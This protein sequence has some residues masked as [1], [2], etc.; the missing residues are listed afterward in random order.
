MTIRPR[1]SA[2]YM[3]GSNARAMEKAR[4]L[5]ADCIILDLED[6]V[7]PDQ[8]AQAR[9]AVVDTLRQGKFGAR[10]VA[11]RINSLESPWGRDDLAALAPLGADALLLP[12]VSHP[13]EIMRA[14]KEARD[15]G[16]RDTLRLWAMMETPMA[17]LNADSI[18]R[19]AGD[20]ASRLAVLVM[21]TNDLAKE[22]RARLRPGRAAMIPWLATCVLAARAHGLDLLDGVFG[23]IADQDGLRAE[24]EQGRDMGFDG[25]TLIHPAQLAVCNEAFSPSEDDVAW[26]R[27]VIAAFDRPENAD[28]GV[29]VLEGRMVERLHADMARRVLAIVEAVSARAA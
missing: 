23:D 4:S 15:A 6:A 16:A 29:I 18:A 2:L 25:K 1:R 22:T 10:E 20:P 3:P 27:K 14:A 24:C 5:P 7:A 17:I 11:V 13:G 26:S 28:R 12:K 8:K 19:T 9:A 21:G